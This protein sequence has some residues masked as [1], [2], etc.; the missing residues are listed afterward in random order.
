MDDVDGEEGGVGVEE[1]SSVSE[2]GMVKVEGREVT[3]RGVG[4]VSVG[5]GAPV[6]I[7]GVVVSEV[8]L[9]EKQMNTHN[10]NHQQ[11]KTS[12]HQ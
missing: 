2:V 4:G 9:S 6:D 11:M 10:L 5:G 7:V 12:T 1:V 8:L 3:M